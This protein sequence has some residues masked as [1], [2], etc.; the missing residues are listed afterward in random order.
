MIIESGS[1]VCSTE[2]VKMVWC[3]VCMGL[4]VCMCVDVFLLSWSIRLWPCLNSIYICPC[5]SMSWRCIYMLDAW[6][7][8]CY[9]VFVRHQQHFQEKQLGPLDEAQ[10][11]EICEEALFINNTSKWLICVR[12]DVMYSYV[13]KIVW[14]W[15]D[16][17]ILML[18]LSFV[19]TCFPL[20]SFSFCYLIGYGLGICLLNGLLDWI[21]LYCRFFVLLIFFL[22]RSTPRTLAYTHDDSREQLEYSER[23]SRIWK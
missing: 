15:N 20:Y 2:F 7:R 19:F 16:D 18:I 23:V 22:Y 21:G 12:W 1:E 3:S 14:L 9:V 17:G 13:I 11:K 10:S 6:S 8:T 4:C 5:F